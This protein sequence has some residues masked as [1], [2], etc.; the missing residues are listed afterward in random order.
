MKQLAG[1]LLLASWLFVPLSA[2]ADPSDSLGDQAKTILQAHC[3]DC[4][5]GGKAAKGGFGF[6]LDRDQLVSRRLV[7]PGKAGQSELFLRIQQGEMPPPA[8]K[9]RP[10]QAE[11]TVLKRWI[12]AGAPLFDKPLQLAKVLSEREVPGAILADLEQLDP[13]RRRFT[14]YL[15][16]THLAFAK[17]PAHDL[18]L[19]REAT[20]KLLNSLSWHP[21]VHVP[22][23]IADGT[24]LRIDLRDYKWSAGLWEKLAA[25]YPYRVRRM[26]VAPQHAIAEH[27]GTDIAA[28]RAD[29]FVATASRPPLYHDLLQLPQTDRAL[30]RLLQVD[31][32]GNQQDDNVVRAGF[33]DSGVSKNNRL[34]E[35]HDAAHGALWRSYDF[36]NNFGRQNLFDHP[37]G[38]STGATSFQAAGGEM[39]FHLPNGLQAYLLVDA[40]GRRIDKAPGE[41]VADP[42]RPD[43]RV[44]TGISCMSC[45]ARGLLFKADHLRAHV[46]KNAQAFGN[47]VVAA[48]RAIHP[49]PAKFKA[50]VEADNVVYLKALAAFGA[51]DPDQE[52]VNLVTQRFEA[53]LD[54]QTAAAELGL[55]VAEF[56]RFLKQ[57]PALARLFGGLLV[58]GGTAQREVFQENF[59]ELA[60]RLA[61]FQA[62][63]ARATTTTVAPFQGHSGTVNCVAFSPDGKLA[64]S[65]GDDRTVRVWDIGSGKELACL[66]SE[67]AEV[68]AVAFSRDGR[69]L[70]SGG[71]DRVLRLWDV[72]AGK[73]LRLLQGHTDSVRCV[74]FSPDGSQAISGGDDRSLR[75]WDVAGAQEVAALAGHTGAVTSVAWSQNGQ[76]VLSGSVDAS[77]RFW[78]SAGR[79]QLAC[80]EGH[81]GPVLSV[82][83]APDGQS[84]L[85]GGNDK[86]LRLWSLPTGNQSHCFKGHAN[87]VIHVQFAAAGTVL[88]SSSQHKNPD[89]T[90]RRWDV[91]QRTEIGAL[92]PSAEISFG[93]V[94]FSPD[95]RHV[96][97]GGPAGFL[98]LWSW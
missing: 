30:E 72:A 55:T 28:L 36:A 67:G 5:G 69:F 40:L 20:G 74:A 60:R 89:R 31:V 15:T 68:Y 46:E 16:L 21:R 70:L 96:L 48:V 42:R 84:A 4:H 63:Y 12:D 7:L 62:A 78:D 86:T 44:E 66:K 71:R 58:P 43:Q 24:I 32:P 95:G 18:Q 88:S 34:L 56:G 22:E 93:C 87:A 25:V 2:W 45:H 73:Q 41:I 49:R 97:A 64:A 92:A 10:N 57:E 85:T 50:Q 19:T 14:R 79:K 76:H 91:K 82:A 23:A 75:I 53:T 51:R 1:F 33:N 29:W 39:I 8:R 6:V 17:R 65:G 81:A 52:P 90:W 35:R 47:E 26:S 98:R 83:L 3:A 80:L 61:L 77:A 27:T 37:L 38:P 9:T 13:R 94:A 54:G 59:A 11:L